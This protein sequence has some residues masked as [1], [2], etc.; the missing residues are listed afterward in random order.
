MQQYYEGLLTEQPQGSNNYPPSEKED[1][2][3]I[4]I[5]IRSMFLFEELSKKTFEIKTTL[6]L[7]IY[8]YSCLLA[9]KE[10]D[11]TFDDFLNDCD[12]HPELIK[13]FMEQLQHH[14]EVN[15]QFV[16]ETNEVSKKK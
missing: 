16:D 11:R 7:Y 10:Y 8:Y 13:W 1:L 2:K 9:G 3:K 6:D 5:G 15:N 4:R 12:T 14:N